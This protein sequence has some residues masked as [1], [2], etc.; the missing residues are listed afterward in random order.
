MKMKTIAGWLLLLVGLIIMLWGLYY[1]FNIFT[2][3]TE[4][5]ELFK[6][7]EQEE[8]VSL[9]SQKTPALGQDIQSQMEEMMGEQIGEQFK[10]ILPPGFLPMLFNLMA[11]SIFAGIL[12]L[13]GAQISGLGIK[14][15][16]P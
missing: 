14:L 6:I 1:S 13:G 5:P 10:Q 15:L 3:K 4:V 12:I 8:A 16:R 2:A 7:E 11:W 9:K